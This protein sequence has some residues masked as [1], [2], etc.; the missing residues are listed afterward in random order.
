MAA[1]A[2]TW[3]ASAAPIWP[4]SAVDSAL[5]RFA[6]LWTR[7][8]Q[9]RSWPRRPATGRREP[10]PNCDEV[11]S[12]AGIVDLAAFSPPEQRAEVRRLAADA[13]PERGAAEPRRE[14]RR[15]Q[16]TRR[17]GSPNPPA[18]LCLDILENLVTVP[19]RS[20]RSVPPSLS[21]ARPMDNAGRALYDRTN[22]HMAKQRAPDGGDSRGWR[23]GAA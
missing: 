5:K 21:M 11:A 2:T 19:S 22:V 8:A 9:R 14:R 20:T 1:T 23:P 18:D 17:A 13:V 3:P 7:C 12:V 6:W 10:Q 16:S 15:R 4:L